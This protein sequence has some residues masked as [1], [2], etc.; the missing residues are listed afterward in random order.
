MKNNYYI[1]TIE[2]K[3]NMNHKKTE[4]EIEKLFERQAQEYH[5]GCEYFKSKITKVEIKYEK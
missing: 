5:P 2:I 3:T 1:F 4:E